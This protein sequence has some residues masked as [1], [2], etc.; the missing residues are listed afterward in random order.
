[1]PKQPTPF[2]DNY[3]FIARWIDSYG[4]IEIGQ[5]DF[6]SSLIRALDEGGMI[7]ESAKKYS[8][9]DAALRDLEIALM[10]AINE[11]G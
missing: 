9:V 1:M 5:D 7:W 11:I 8:S 6:S 2:E 10:K 3:P 4:W